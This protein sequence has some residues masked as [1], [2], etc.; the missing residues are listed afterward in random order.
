VFEL[1][2]DERFAAPGFTHPDGSP[3]ELFSSDNAATVQRHFE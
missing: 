1:T 2:K 3:A